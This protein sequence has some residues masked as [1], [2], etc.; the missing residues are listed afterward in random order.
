MIFGDR[1]KQARELKGLSQTELAEGVGLSQSLVA[2][3]ESGTKEPSEEFL[4]A[5]VFQLGFSLAF[6]E[7]PPTDDFPQGSLLFRAHVS[8]GDWEQRRVYRW[9]QTVFGL[10]TRM[11]A[12]RRV[13]E[14]PLHLPRCPGDDP[15]KAAEI[16]RSE[17]GLSPDTPVPNVINAIEK[18]GVLALALPVNFEGVDAFSLWATSQNGQRRP[19][20]AIVGNRP[21][22]RLRMSVAH[23]LGHLI[24]HQ[25]LVI[26]MGDV[27]EQAKKFAGCFLMPKASMLQEIVPPVSLETFVNLKPKW[28]VAIQALIVRSYELDII[29]QRQYHYL[30]AKLAKRGWK[31]REPRSLEVPLE[32][33]RALRQTAELLYGFP[34]N[35]QRLSSDTKLHEPFVREV[36]ELH[37]GRSPAKAKPKAEA[38]S[39]GVIRFPAGRKA[40]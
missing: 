17:M 40:R 13:R 28:G 14:V 27:E 2:Q 5:L 37:A 16:A 15:E 36:M 22:D 4:A 1:I 30:F 23:E 33:P 24:M 19:V 7:Q 9:A 29:T 6:F 34:I 25:P 35:Y 20:M 32:R 10:Y 38:P 31:L 8:L 26:G 12:G 3:I 11:I 21:P 18:A 39:S